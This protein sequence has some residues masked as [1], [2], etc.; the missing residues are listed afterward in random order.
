[1]LARAG[2][3]ASANY[4]Q[5]QGNVIE[6]KRARTV[7]NCTVRSGS[8]PKSHDF[9]APLIEAEITSAAPSMVAHQEGFA[10]VVS[11]F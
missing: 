1:M 2:K 7:R 8:P 6:K 4:S 9:G 3:G 11:R 10:L 5:L